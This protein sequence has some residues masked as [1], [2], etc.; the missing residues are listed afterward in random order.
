[1]SL[2]RSFPQVRYSVR[3]IRIDAL[4]L[5]V[6]CGGSLR[7]ARRVVNRAEKDPHVDGADIIKWT[8]YEFSG[9]TSEIVEGW[10]RES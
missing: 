7:A 9:V 3:I 2:F 6:P 8:E 5:G 10:R 4:V 1:M